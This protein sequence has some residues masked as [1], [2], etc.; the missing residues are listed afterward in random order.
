M[1]RSTWMTCA[2]CAV[3]LVSAGAGAAP[4]T[5]GSL[6]SNDDGSTTVITDALNNREWL[7]WNVLLGLTYNQTLTA[8]ANP[9][10]AAYGFTVARNADAQAFIDAL[11]GSR[12]DNHCSASGSGR[13]WQ[14]TGSFP[15][16]SSFTAL[17]GDTYIQG[18]DHSAVY[19]LSD[20][21]AGKDVGFIET[22]IADIWK[23][24][25]WSTFGQADAQAVPGYQTGSLG[26]TWLLYRDL[27]P[28]VSPVPEPVSTGVLLAAGL[29]FLG[30]GARR[31]R[32]RS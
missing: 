14:N 10:S 29:T 1:R 8:I 23:T 22:R 27:P 26:I 6:S 3:L 24:N 4:V 32:A 30:A 20:N 31:R 7:R 2:I 11:F 28:P 9:G 16:A 17:W 25:E 18:N 21:G 13:C 5:I 19:F 15:H 12:D